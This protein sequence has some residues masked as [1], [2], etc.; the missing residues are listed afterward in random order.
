M[1]KYTVLNRVSGPADIRKLSAAELKLLAGEVRDYMLSVV[2]VNG[3]HLASSLGAVEVTI[4]L[5]KTFNPPEDKIIWDVGH[6]AYSYKILTGRR[7][8]FRTLRKYKGISGFLKRDESKYDFFGAGHT[9]TSIS[10]GMG[11]AKARDIMGG[12]EKVVSVIGDASLANGMSLE[13]INHIGQNKTD[14]LVVVIDNEMSISPT[15]GALSNYLNR[16]IS[17]KF[18]NDLKVRTRIMIEK[19]P[20]IGVP[21]ANV[22]KHVE[23]GIRSVLSPGMI[24]E[25]LGFRYF[26][27]ID[28]HDIEV[29]CRTLKN[30][31][32]IKGPKLLHVITKK[33]KGYLPAEENPT[34][35]HG[36]GAFK[37]QTGEVIKKAVSDPTYSKIFSE[38][39]VALASRNKRISAIVAAMIEGT[40]LSKFQML[41][42]E[43]FFD[44]GIAEEHAVT[45]AAGLA[46]AGMRPVVAV[47]S[48]FM[49]RSVDQIIHDVGMQKLPVVFALDRAGLVG[50]DG[51]T[52]HGVFDIV[53]MKM[54]P[55]MV[56]MAPSD[57]LELE[58]MLDAA[59]EYEGGPV[60]IR[61]PRGES[62]IQKDGK[63]QPVK[64][65]RSRIVKRGSAMTVLCLGTM[66]RS[67]LSAVEDVE[68]KKGVR[69]EI[70][71]ARFAKPV[72]ERLI[73]ESVSKTGALLV[74]E[75][76]ALEGGYGQSVTQM[77][78]GNGLKN[79]RIK[80][81][82]I[83]DAFVEQGS[84]DR[85]KHDCGLDVNGIRTAIIGLL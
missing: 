27:P 85:L 73:M 16:I 12:H 53:F 1:K 30:I 69:I 33:G 2:S 61:F 38:K 21:A 57:A 54:V 70:I 41:Y 25:E 51:P 81:I 59:F 82:G 67:V 32:D 24:F 77:L 43:R 8:K 71:D 36:I 68:K 37:R 44:V 6:Q 13:A 15:V 66:L 10:A 74:I 84:M 45:F 31:K 52:H 4:A 63:R 20:K 48:T 80:T 46:A 18:Y 35:F 34:L 40:N 29:L 3:G 19:I 60:S 55:G 64:I 83:P 58:L 49:Q 56:V 76:G 28:G 26:G 47:Y 72:D 75:E 5:L 11:F 50:E 79:I 78:V 39:L 17:G 22:I 23:E 62:W 14:F 7:S 65:G 42:P 9:S